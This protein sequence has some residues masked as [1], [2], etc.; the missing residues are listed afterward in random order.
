[1]KV[2]N[3]TDTNYFQVVSTTNGTTAEILMYGVIGQKDWW[4]DNSEEDITDLAFVRTLRELEQSHSRINIR[5]NSP[6]GSVYH[7]N[8]IVTAIQNSK[9]EIHLYNDGLCA[10]MT[11]NIWT[12]G[13]EG[14]RHMAKNASLMFH[15]PSDIIWGNAKKLRATADKL[16]KI[17]HTSIV[18]LT[19]ATG[20]SKDEVKSQYFDYEDHWFTYQEVIDMGLVTA[21]EEYEAEEVM[22]NAKEKATMMQVLKRFSDKG[23]E[24]ATNFINYIKS[25]TQQLQTVIQQAA[26]FNNKNSHEMT[27]QELKEALA[28]NKLSADEVKAILAETE[29]PAEE[30]PETVTETVEASGEQDSVETLLQ[31]LQDQI[32]QLSDVVTQQQGL[33]K[34]LSDSPGGSPSGVA[35]GGDPHSTSQKSALEDFNEQCSAIAKQGAVA[36]F[37]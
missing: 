20:L 11:A 14:Q 10:S 5:I 18:V 12:A 13:K 17:E 33:I 15:S 32:K 9:S 24:Q 6:G 16:D 7:G 30:T 3:I 35:G 4:G 29:T 2:A 21:D 37:S 26:H 27:I 36:H 1:M 31:P 34:K 28:E 8:A 22:V 23:D 25:K 19:E